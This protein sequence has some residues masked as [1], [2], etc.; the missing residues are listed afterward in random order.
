MKINRN[1]LCTA[2]LVICLVVIGVGIYFYISQKNSLDAANQDLTTTK[3]ALDTTKQALDTTKQDLAIATQTNSQCQNKYTTFL[4]ILNLSKYLRDAGYPVTATGESFS[5]S[6]ITGDSTNIREEG[7]SLIYVYKLQPYI[8]DQ[9][10]DMQIVVFLQDNTHQYLLSIK[11]LQR[12]DKL[13]L[14]ASQRIALQIPV[15]TDPTKFTEIQFNVR[16]YGEQGTTVDNSFI[17]YDIND[18]NVINPQ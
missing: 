4:K 17:V 16:L 7:N 6:L 5:W 12:A 10:S 18:Y 9:P 14:K 13:N 3:Q 11:D 1:I 15:K 2:S 8:L